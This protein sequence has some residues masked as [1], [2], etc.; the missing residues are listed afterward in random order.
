[1]INLDRYHPVTVFHLVI[2]LYTGHY[3]LCAVRMPKALRDLD[4]FDLEL[5][6]KV[7]GVNDNCTFAR[8]LPAEEPL[9]HLNMYIAARTHSM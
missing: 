3:D 2:F 9:T 6:V 5:D 4:I 8:P 7:P 1:M